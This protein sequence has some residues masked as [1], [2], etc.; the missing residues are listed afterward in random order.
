MQVSTTKQTKE[1][2]RGKGTMLQKNNSDSVGL[3]S[4]EAP[5]GASSS[6]N[7]TWRTFNLRVCARTRRARMHAQRIKRKSL[8]VR[9][10]RATTALPLGICRKTLAEGSTT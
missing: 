6:V 5:A 4:L 9:G 10:V 7:P 1:K 2:Q 3:P 8:K